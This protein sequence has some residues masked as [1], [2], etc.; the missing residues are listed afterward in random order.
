MHS[1]H[2]HWVVYVH[3]NMN[4]HKHAHTHIRKVHAVT[5]IDLRTKYLP[6][7]I[8]FN[9]CFPCMCVKLTK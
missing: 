9:L 5:K 2:M 8:G 1:Q 4:R 6:K 7:Q 3:K